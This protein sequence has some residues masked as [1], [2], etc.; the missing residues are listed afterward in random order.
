MLEKQI[1]KRELSGELLN[2]RKN[3]EE[4]ANIFYNSAAYRLYKLKTGLL[5]Y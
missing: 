4:V 5:N 3:L 2:F 1:N